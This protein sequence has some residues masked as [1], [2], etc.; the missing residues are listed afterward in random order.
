MLSELAFYLIAALT[1]GFAMAAMATRS[2]VNAAFCAAAAFGGLAAIYLNLDAEFVGF[3]QLLVYVGA[4]AILI[5]FAVL[6][7]NG[8]E[9]RPGTQYSS[10][11]W[12]TG[13]AAAALVFSVLTA[14]IISS[15]SLQRT[16]P[17]AAAAPVKKIGQELMTRYVLPLEMVGVLLTAALL[18]AVVIAMHAEPKTNLPEPEP[19]RPVAPAQPTEKELVSR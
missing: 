2:L 1:L 14:V 8:D 17:I 5:V 15:P 16:A 13:V 3:A 7:T 12:K 18:G 4:V 6:L 9:A 10:P 11:F 19:P